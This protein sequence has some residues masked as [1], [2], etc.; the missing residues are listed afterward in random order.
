MST[1][2]ADECPQDVLE[3]ALAAAGTNPCVVLVTEQASVNL[4]WALTGLTTN[5]VRHSRSVTAVVAAPVAGGTS[6]ATLSRDGLDAEGAAELVTQARDAARAAGPVEDAADL[7]DGGVSPD[8]QEPPAG[9]GPAALAGVAAGLGESFEACLA[10]GRESFGFALHEVTTTYLGTSAGT[11]RRQ[12]QPRGTFE[13]T[14]KSHARSRSAW[15]GRATRDF[16]DV[17]VA[18][19]DAEIAQRLSWQER[20]VEVAAGRHDAVLPPSAVADLMVYLL[21]SSDARSAHEGRSAFSRAGGGT[22]V[23]GRLT[24]APLTLRSDPAHPGL[25]CADHLATATSSPFASVFD[26]GMPVPAQTWLREGVLERLPT[27]RHT[28]TVTGLPLA[29]APSNLVLTSEQGR[30]GLAEQVGGL[31]DGLLLT[32]LWY[33]REV[34]PAS[35]LLTGLT[36]DGVYRVQGGE[37]T[38]AV[39]NFRFNESP[40]DL[41]GRVRSAGLTE[42]T[43]SREWG[44]YFTRTAMPALTVSGFNFSSPSQAS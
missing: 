40:V 14:G 29:V 13:L 31:Q 27:T 20:R 28:S 24:A 34:D 19:L 38:G 15:V 8:W 3:R 11:R 37:V 39:G 2:R 16:S 22:R 23:G 6:V 7:L 21:W 42:P 41:L 4:R 25:E 18:V 35:L 17:D 44:E 26:N 30:G 10:Q 33:I 9:T 36:R 32:C 1:G 5:G 43:L 12:E